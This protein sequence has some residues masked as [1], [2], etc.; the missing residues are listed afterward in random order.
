MNSDYFAEN[1]KSLLPGACRWIEAL[2]PQYGDAPVPGAVHITVYAKDSEGNA[3]VITELP[4]ALQDAA[5]QQ[6]QRTSDSV[7]WIWAQDA[8][9][10]LVKLSALPVSAAQL[11]RQAG[12]DAASALKGRRS[13]QVVFPRYSRISALDV[14][15]GLCCGFYEPGFFKKKSDQG[16]AFLPG[17]VTFLTGDEGFEEKRALV[18]AYYL[19]R[20]LQD[21]PSNLLTPGVMGT[22][23]KE[24]SEDAGITCRRYR[25]K[26]LE[27]FGMGSML[28]VSQGSV[29]EP[30]FIVMEIPGEDS[31]RTAVLAGKGLT[32]D[33]GGISLKPSLDLD[34]MKYDMSGGA[35]VIGAGIF[36]GSLEKK[37]P[38]NVVCLVGAVENMPGGGAIKPGDVL[39]AMNGKTIEVLNTDA[40]GR[41]VLADVISYA[42][43][44]YDPEFIIDAATLTGGVVIALGR[45][46]SG[47]MGNSPRLSAYLKHISE[48]CG[49][50][51][52]ELPMWPELEEETL[53][54]FGDVKNIPRP[55]V[56]ASSIMGAWFIKQFAEETPWV[57]LDIA[58]TAWGCSA[59]GYVKEQSSAFGLRLMAEACLGYEV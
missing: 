21:T 37:P 57:H 2:E 45:A 32:F 43:K 12:I 16:D 59:L 19:T 15:D 33:T 40:E 25:R 36:L 8:E 17:G 24:A 41:L 38:V 31:S 28:G 51:V 30:C 47:I 39:T 6:L 52:W 18:K 53:G 48:A 26:E 35:A 42:R 50:P 13:P 55:A 10:L 56:K 46:G 27:A 22:I 5:L 7:S 11:G 23:A 34:K 4:D 44:F 54:T 20:F 29:H 58:G 3:E 9:L 14:F 1:W 49:E